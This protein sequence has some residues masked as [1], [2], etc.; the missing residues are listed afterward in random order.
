[1][2]AVLTRVSHARV[3][4]D[5]RIVGEITAPDTCGILALVGISRTDTDDDVNLMA[6]KIEELRILPGEKS[7]ADLDAPVL[8]VSQFTL[9]G[10]TAKGRRPTW[11]N[12][13]PG[14]VAQPLFD[15]LTALLIEHGVRVQIGEFGAMMRVS[16]VNEGPFTVL[17]DTSARTGN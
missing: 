9:Q 8:L 7:V 2:K 5:E 13:A 14:E 3:T 12:A 10:N 4:V 1:M 6:R 15:S 11:I 16:S 17:V